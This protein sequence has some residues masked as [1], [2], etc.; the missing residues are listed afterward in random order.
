MR[1]APGAATIRRV[2]GLVCPDGL[3]DP[4]GAD[5]GGSDSTAVD[6]GTARAPGTAKCPPPTCWPQ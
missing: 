4:T 3:T 1:T 6:G 5:P 2:I